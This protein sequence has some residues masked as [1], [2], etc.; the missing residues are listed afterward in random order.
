MQDAGQDRRLSKLSS[1]R[2]FAWLNM[3]STADSILVHAYLRCVPML[4]DLLARGLS[5]L[6][7]FM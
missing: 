3:M 5:L 6:T 2:F 1:E 7:N 4:R